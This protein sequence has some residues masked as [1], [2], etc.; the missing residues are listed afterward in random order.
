M[1]SQFL[2]IF[3]FRIHFRKAPVNWMTTLRISYVKIFFVKLRE[4]KWIVN[5][6][7]R[8]RR[9]II[10][11]YS[12]LFAYIYILRAHNVKWTIRIFLW[13]KNHTYARDERNKCVCVYLPDVS[14][15]STAHDS[16]LKIGNWLP[17]ALRI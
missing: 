16:I 13:N 8:I 9:L 17:L 11:T 14:K 3:S 15:I 2:R 1:Y 5:L 10:L 12:T 6:I 7:I 4:P